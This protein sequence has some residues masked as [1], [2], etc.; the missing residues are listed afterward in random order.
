MN[1]LTDPRFRSPVPTIISW[2]RVTS[3]GND[4]RIDS[5]GYVNR[6]YSRYQHAFN[7]TG[8]VTVTVNRSSKRR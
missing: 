8:F 2:Q 3:D 6:V 4:A 5:R 7:E 1:T